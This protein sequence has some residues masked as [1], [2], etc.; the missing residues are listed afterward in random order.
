MVYASE[1]GAQPPPAHI[2][3]TT[4]MV[5]WKGIDSKSS[6][7]KNCDYQIK[8]VFVRVQTCITKILLKRRKYIYTVETIGTLNQCNLNLA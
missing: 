2:L 8:I 3:V 5:S 7:L 1:N 6:V 4:Q